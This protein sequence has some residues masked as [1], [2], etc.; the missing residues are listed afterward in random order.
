MTTPEP[1]ICVRCHQPVTAKADQYELFEHMHWLCFHLEFEH[2]ADPD[3]PC[4]DPSCPWWHIET[5]EAA[6]TRLGHDPARIVEQAFEER[7]RR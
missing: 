2:Q 7:Y 4:D 6:L 1:L 3:V 5:L